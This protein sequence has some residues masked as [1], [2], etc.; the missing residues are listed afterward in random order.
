MKK[1]LIIGKGSYIGEH[2]K[3]YIET[4]TENYTVDEMDT[5][6]LKPRACNFN[7]IDTIIYVAGIAHIKETDKNR[8]LYYKINRDLTVQVATTAKEQGVHQFIFLSSMSVYGKN[9]G[10]ITEHTRPEP[11][12]SYGD[13]KLQAE[14]LISPLRD[15]NFK[16]TILRPPMVYGKNCKGNFQ[17]VLKII[18]KTPIFPEIHNIRSM[19]YIDH[20][21]EFIKLCVVEERD[22]LYFP[23]NSTHVQTTGMAKIIAGEK[24]RKVFFSKLLGIIVCLI[25]PFI[26]MANKAFGSLIYSETE[27]DNFSYCTVDETDS[28]KMSV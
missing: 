14:Q 13:S 20:L 2:I 1:I 28:F 9:S 11:V 5:Y 24:N 22:G 21:C 7:G 8:N 17:T 23:Q 18:D 6:N 26:P 25:R 12:N 4:T 10:V 27:K 15:K 19:I 3:N 16:V